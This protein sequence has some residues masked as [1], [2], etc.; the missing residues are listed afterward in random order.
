MAKNFNETSLLLFKILEL[1]SRLGEKTPLGLLSL[2]IN[3]NHGNEFLN[4]NINTN[5]KNG[6]MEI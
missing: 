4:E 5:E 3:I 2:M 6:G 1:N